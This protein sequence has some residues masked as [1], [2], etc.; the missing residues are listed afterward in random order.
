MNPFR[1]L[2]AGDH[3]AGSPRSGKCLLI[4]ILIVAIAAIVFLVMELVARDKADEERLRQPSRQ[5]T[6]EELE[7][8]R[9]EKMVFLENPEVARDPKIDLSDKSVSVM[10]SQLTLARRRLEAARRSRANAEA[11]FKRDRDNQRNLEDRLAKLDAEFEES[12]DDDELAEQ[13]GELD[14]RLEQSRSTIAQAEADLALM[15][16]Y[17]KQM[18]RLV[19]DME[20]AVA[21]ARRSGESVVATADMDALKTHFDAE[22]SAGTVAEDQRR[23]SQ[24]AANAHVAEEV[25]RSSAARDRARARQERRRAA[26]GE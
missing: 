2:R 4:V 7:L 18:A 13:I 22:M 26:Q 25:G 14:L 15:R 10:E 17:E 16:S 8:D 5:P 24:P 20:A 23:N 11:K 19:Q 12:P 9:I 21:R 1:L 3:F 6:A